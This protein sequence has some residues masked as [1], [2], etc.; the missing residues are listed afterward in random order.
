MTTRTV[1]IFGLAYGSSPAEISVTLDGATVYAGT[2]PTLDQPVLTI[3]D[4]EMVNATTEFCTFE[5]PMD[6]SGTIPMT[7]DV[8]AG[9]VIFAQILANY[10]TIA[11]TNPVV[12][13]GSDEYH[14]TTDRGV[15]AR[16]NVVINGVPKPA[17]SEAPPG[18]LWHTL[19][20]GSTLSYDLNVI[21][22]TANVA[23]VTP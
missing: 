21:A 14:N 8:V 16:S 11:N 1:K 10:C 18:S 23:P 4:P 17:I 5:I 19:S 9:T 3:P 6:F 13:T 7:C 20:V 2:V 12:G 15:D 22:G